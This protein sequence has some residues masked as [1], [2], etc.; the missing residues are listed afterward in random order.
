MQ[1]ARPR[2][3]QGNSGRLRLPPVLTKKTW[4]RPIR[5]RH[6]ETR[7]PAGGWGL[8]ADYRSRRGR[9]RPRCRPIEAVVSGVPFTGR[10]VSCKCET[11]PLR[12]RHR[13]QRSIARFALWIRIESLQR[14]QFRYGIRVAAPLGTA[15]HVQGVSLVPGSA[16]RG[17]FSHIELSPRTSRGNLAAL[18][19]RPRRWFTGAGVG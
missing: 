3:R 4:W 7:M 12:A 8:N 17:G 2:A 11:R 6:Q 9:R 10:S 14:G 1:S 15:K 13:G 5:G 18:A 19:R 16:A